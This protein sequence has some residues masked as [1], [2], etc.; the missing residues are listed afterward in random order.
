MP[1]CCRTVILGTVFAVLLADEIVDIGTHFLLWLEEVVDLAGLALS[2]AV[3]IL[4]HESIELLGVIHTWRVGEEALKMG[5]R[6][7]PLLI[8]S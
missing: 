8:L 6:L 4:L 1:Y 3:N 2:L 7:A 5:C